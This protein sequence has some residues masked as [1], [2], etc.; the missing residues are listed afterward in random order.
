L[1]L[2]FNY[3]WE[4]NLHQFTTWASRNA[5]PLLIAA[6]FLLGLTL[7]ASGVVFRQTYR[8]SQHEY[9]LWLQQRATRTF[10]PFF[11]PLH[12]WLRLHS[13]GYRWW[14]AQIYSTTLHTL[15]FL[16]ILVISLVSIQ[17]T[18]SPAPGEPS[19]DEGENPDLDI[20][21]DTTWST[22]VCYG[23]VTI[24]NE[25]TLTINGGVAGS[26]AALTI[27]NSV[28]GETGHI[29]FKG[30]TLNN[31]GV[32]LTISSD[33]DL[34]DGS[35]MTGNGWG[36]AGG[37]SGSPNGAGSGGGVGDF[38]TGGLGNTYAGG[39]G[40]GG[41]GG[42]LNGAAGGSTYGSATAPDNLGSG[43]GY[44][45]VDSVGS[46]GG[47][48]GSAVKIDVDGTFTI[49]GLISANGANSS[50][51][52]GGSGGSIWMIANSFAGTGTI[53]AN[54]GNGGTNGS[55]GG[56]GRIVRQY[57]AAIGTGLTLTATQ[58]TG[59]TGSALGTITNIGPAS[60]FDVAASNNSPNV[61]AGTAFSITV[62]AKDSLGA[63][64][65]SYAGTVSFSSTDS[66]ATVPSNY[67]FVPGDNG[68]KTFSSVVLKTAGSKTITATEVGNSAVT[69]VGNFNVSAASASSVE[70]SVPV[71]AV[72]AGSA[73]SATVTAKDA[74]GN[75]A[76]TFNETIH[77]AS[78]DPQ[79]VLPADYTFITADQ[80]V[81]TFSNQVV[82]K[83]VGTRSITVQ[84]ES[85]KAESGNVAVSPAPAS[86]MVI[87][88]IP[89]TVTAG[90]KLSPT[91][92][93][94]DP[95]GNTATGYNR[96]IRFSSTDS[97]AAVPSD[98][99]FVD[100]DGGV[101]TFVETLILKTAG[102]MT[103]TVTELR[104]NNSV[105]SKSVLLQAKKDI[106]VNP[107]AHAAY[108]I[109]TTSPQ[110]VG[111]GW[112]ETLNPIDAYGNSVTL[113]QKSVLT[114]EVSGPA[115]VYADSKYTDEATE[116]VLASSSY[117]IYVKA[118]AAGKVT[119]TATDENKRTGHSG[120]I[121][122]NIG[123][124]TPPTT[125]TPPSTT[126]PP[127]NT[128]TSSG[129]G[130]TQ[131]VNEIKETIKK[132]TVA[133]NKTLSEN[134]PIVNAANI[135]AIAVSPV[136]TAVALG[137]LSTTIVTAIIETL[138]KGASFFGGVFGFVPSARLRGRRWGLVRNRRS[139]LPVGGVFVE[140]IDETGKTIDR[141]MTDRTGHYAF[142]VEK[143]GRY[144]VQVRNPLYERF[145]SRPI[146]VHNPGEDIINENIPLQLIEEQLKARMNTVNLLFK[147]MRFLSWA[148]W[149]LLVV[150]SVL[151]V[152]V[153]AADQTLLKALVV[154]LYVLL[155]STKIL[156]LDYRR[157]Y[158]VVVDA[159]SN[160]PQPLS[161][162]QISSV[163]PQGIGVVRSTITD[164]RGRFL[165]VIKPG[166]YNL[167]VGKEG[168]QPAEMQIQGR[169]VNLTVKLRKS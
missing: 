164:S 22:D 126:T 25:A 37:T 111:K 62:T 24:T 134:E 2:R 85:A 147:L 122:V 168:Y 3:N 135:T 93:L 30:D 116:H 60:S 51:G 82:F 165:F 5:E 107:G 119:L 109:T 75:V 101:K 19:C 90:Q 152:Y 84:S 156:E 103:A 131:V 45:V 15:V 63:T 14:H 148:H 102:L 23:T 17:T 65:T 155:W 12:D 72:T 81:K 140:L 145:L 151:A 76:T 157:P 20:T 114:I 92:T 1:W 118:S 99:T 97:N 87:S 161:V 73:T 104:D 159:L 57:S 88:N 34:Q 32:G 153:Y 46:N 144:W 64:V 127:G 124:T 52:A 110:L 42:S 95:Y 68:V 27:G 9:K 142:L 96:T 38:S 66:Q 18:L 40:Y 89:G 16:L 11:L 105:F 160:K 39:G 10:F 166:K 150:G 141:T 55:G 77:F 158:G 83:T 58:G 59:G 54:G 91:I 7:I 43:G 154:S 121:T 31:E 53:Q 74:Y 132:A 80:G 167:L 108:K 61:T 98:Y 162:V 117:T 137:P 26:L 136:A 78:S 129:G 94:L 128:G 4:V 143:P 67:T 115:K 139:G 71:N 125:T 133:I 41:T 112:Q 79:A 100:A 47:N 113:S 56:G 21:V 120:V 28:G 123:S 169:A 149:P 29:V 6:T 86:Q 130:L 48:G 44:A 69:G 70:V 146:T 49:N 50:G 36:Y 163:S 8:L 13:K 138:A 33:V 106:T 35:T